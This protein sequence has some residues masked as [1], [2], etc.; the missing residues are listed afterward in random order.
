MLCMQVMLCML[1]VALA[2]NGH[3]FS[4][5]SR[6]HTMWHKYCQSLQFLL[7]LAQE[8][9]LAC[10]LAQVINFGNIVFPCGCIGVSCLGF[11]HYRSATVFELLCTL[12]LVDIASA[13]KK[14]M[15]ER[16]SLVHT[17]SCVAILFRCSP[18]PN[19]FSAKQW[20]QL[21]VTNVPVTR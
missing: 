5:N 3:T 20:L 18:A 6:D 7:L 4:S 11:I 14:W 17:A 8:C 19:T 16:C 12:T 15:T 13:H 2:P 21:T 9:S 1:S 10:L